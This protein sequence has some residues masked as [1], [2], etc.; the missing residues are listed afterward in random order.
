MLF[1][2][3]LVA[4]AGSQIS[5]VKDAC[6]SSDWVVATVMNSSYAD[7]YDPHRQ[8]IVWPVLRRI[9]LRWEAE[10]AIRNSCEVVYNFHVFCPKEKAKEI[11]K[12]IFA[13]AKA[14]G[15]DSGLAVDAISKGYIM[16]RCTGIRIP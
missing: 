12:L 1:V 16:Q 11:Q 6:C 7:N 13:D 14:N 9:G 4:F 2:V 8:V 5:Q 3:P 10:K 15:Y